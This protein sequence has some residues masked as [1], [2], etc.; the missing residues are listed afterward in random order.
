VAYDHASSG[1]P[2]LPILRS[3]NE[4]RGDGHR[5]GQ[6]GRVLIAMLLIGIAAACSRGDAAPRGAPVNVH[7]HDFAL[8]T[9]APL[10]HAGYVTFH[11]HN[12][13]PSTHEFIVARTDVAADALPLHKDDITVDEDSPQI[14]EVGSLGGVRLDATRNLTLKLDPGHYVLFCNFAGHYRGGMYALLTVAD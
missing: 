3:V 2:S 12:T 4:R 10:V 6:F 14:H 13:G 5:R 7:E 9:D 8:T 11:V 1:Y